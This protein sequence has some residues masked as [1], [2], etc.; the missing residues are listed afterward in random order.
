MARK[1]P[2][3]RERSKSLDRLAPFED[4]CVMVVIETP[5]GSPNKGKSFEVK[6]HA[7]KERAHALVTAAMKK[8]SGRSPV[9]QNR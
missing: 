2:A 1:S 9:V 3:R 7:G 8:R 4:D 6:G 5:K